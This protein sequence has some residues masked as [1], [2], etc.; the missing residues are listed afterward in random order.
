MHLTLSMLLDSS[1]NIDNTWS[2]T[3]QV[4]VMSFGSLSHIV[5]ARNS[6]HVKCT[7]LTINLS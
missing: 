5:T 7:N 6:R 3:K 1:N 2:F 4:A